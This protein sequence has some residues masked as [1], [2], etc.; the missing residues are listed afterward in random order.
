LIAGEIK[1]GDSIVIDSVEGKLTFK[2]G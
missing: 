2:Q 1:D